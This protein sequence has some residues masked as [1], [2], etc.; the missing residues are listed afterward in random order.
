MD[1]VTI[2]LLAGAGMG[3]LK[4]GEERRKAEA[5]RQLQAAVATYSPWTGMQ[6]DTNFQ[7]PN[8][9]GNT[10]QGAMGGAML[11]QGLGGLGGGAAAG[12]VDTSNA[13]SAVDPSMQM[14]QQQQFSKYYNT[15]GYTPGRSQSFGWA[16]S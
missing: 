13:T 5:D 3:V 12:G 15:P 9:M 8:V 6:A 7:D 16:L 11:G 1:P 4:S 14:T 10:M 2:G